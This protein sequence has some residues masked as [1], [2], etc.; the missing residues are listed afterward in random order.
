M[1]KVAEQLNIGRSIRSC[2]PDG[3]TLFHRG[4]LLLPLLALSSDATPNAVANA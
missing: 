3:A 2:V 1:M 4:Y